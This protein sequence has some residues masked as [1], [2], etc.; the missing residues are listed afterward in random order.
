MVAWISITNHDISYRKADSL[1][2]AQD[3]MNRPKVNDV[4]DKYVVILDQENM[5]N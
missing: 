3:M 2:P 1:S 4:F 5:R